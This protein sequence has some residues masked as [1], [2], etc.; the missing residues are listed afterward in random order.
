MDH[1]PIPVRIPPLTWRKPVFLWTPLA[2]AA[3]IGWPALLFQN[4]GALQK[5]AVVA[6]AAVFALAMVTLGIAWGTGKAPRTRRTVVIHVL[7]AGAIASLLAPFV[8]TTLLAG[9]AD[10]EHAGDGARFS[11]EMSL[12]MVPLGL[13]IGLPVGLVSGIVFAW[14]GL[15]RA[16][17]EDDGLG[18]FE[19]QPFR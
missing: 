10:Y 19:T 12:A 13:V 15:T 8:L 6:G 3:A 18:A 14:L 5:L 9:V 16:K 17:L 4:D 2:L 7:F 1:P 11:I